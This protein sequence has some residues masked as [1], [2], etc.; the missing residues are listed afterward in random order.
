MVSLISVKKAQQKLVETLRERR[1][2]MNLTQESLAKRSGVALST[3]RKF[4]QGGVISLEYFLKLLF[5]VGGLEEVID[6]LK[7]SMPTFSSIDEVLKEGKS[8][9][10]KRGRK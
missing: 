10:R 1:L 7:P 8:E 6:S 9:N 4:E 2:L 5:V 3:L